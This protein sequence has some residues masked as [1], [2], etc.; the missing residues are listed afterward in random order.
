M[1]VEDVAYNLIHSL[2][3]I[4]DLTIQ[5]NDNEVVIRFRL[6]I[7]RVNKEPYNILMDLADYIGGRV[8]VE[9]HLSV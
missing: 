8:E 7:R 9:T 3:G 4:R 5:M 2:P 6:T 1:K